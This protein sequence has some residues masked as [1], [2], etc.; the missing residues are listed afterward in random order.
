MGKNVLV[1]GAVGF[2]GKEVAVELRRRGHNVTGVIRNGDRSKELITHEINV[3][4]AGA[5]EFTKYEKEFHEADAVILSILDFTGLE[6]EAVRILLSALSKSNPDKKKVLIYTS[7]VLV[8]K[9]NKNQQLTEDAPFSDHPIVLPRIETEKAVLSSKDGHGVIVRP[10]F[11]YGGQ[12][13]HFTLHFQQAEEGKVIVNGKGDNTFSA[14][15]IID[16]A[17]G[18]TR[19]VE[20]NPTVVGGQVFHISDGQKYEALEIGK[21]F[22]AAAGY[23]G[24]I[25]TG[26]PWAFDLF[27]TYVW[28]DN[29]KAERVLGWK[30]TR[31]NMLEE[32]PVLY[33]S[34]KAN[35][36]KGNW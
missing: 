34:W 14:V 35:G 9:G 25:E 6:E 20:A 29:G 13:G 5:T 32:A 36:L 28:V 24:P 17:D 31:K 4:V 18:I 7:G 8:L 2:I 22:G 16:V 33:K 27:D 15:H 21:A 11:I 10:S 23:K 26:A 19:I 30:P 3:V 12:K 1:I